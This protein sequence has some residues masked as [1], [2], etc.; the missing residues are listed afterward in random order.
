MQY[1]AASWRRAERRPGKLALIVGRPARATLAGTFPKHI[2]LENVPAFPTTVPYREGDR[3]PIS[4]RE[5]GD[6][7]GE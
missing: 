5:P 1:L 3:R 6:S 4:L 2:P 7:A